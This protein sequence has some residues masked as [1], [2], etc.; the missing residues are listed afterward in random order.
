[1]KKNQI[2]NEKELES[3]K[4]KMAA[5][6]AGDVMS[7]AVK[8]G[9]IDLIV[10]RLDGQSVDALKTMADDIKAKNENAVIVFASLTDSKI[11]FVA[12][13]GK[14][15]LSSG[16]HCGKIIKEVTTIAGGSGGGKPDM[17]Q[18][19][20][21]DESKIDSALAEVENIVKGQLN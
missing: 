7:S 17:A 4:A 14:N 9:D 8:I 6:K 5:Q 15:A 21:K 19:G 3:I 12:M 18:G 16:V 20:G 10:S 1:M 13:A 11:T 2:L